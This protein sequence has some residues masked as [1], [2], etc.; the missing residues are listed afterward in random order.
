MNLGPGANI[1]GYRIE[2]VLGAGGMG[3]VYL[4]KHPSLPR[5]DAV[6]VLKADVAE[7]R[8][9]RGRFKREANLSAGLDHPN[10]VTVYDRGDD[11]GRL[12][13]AM[14]Y[15]P[16]I[17]AAEV[18]KSHPRGIG[19]ERALRIVR[20]VG[21]GLDHAHRRG[22]LHRDVK[23]A[24]FLLSPGE[25]E[26]VL[27]TDFGVAKAM[28]DSSELTVTGKF[29]ATVA[30]AAPEQLSDGALSRQTDVY[31]LACSFFK[32][33]TGRNLYPGAQPALVMSGHLYEPVPRITE[34]RPELPR[35][36]DEVLAV[37]L[38]K[39]PDDRFGSCREFTQA[40]ELALE[41][42]LSPVSTPTEPGSVA[43]VTVGPRRKAPAR[44]QMWI[45]SAAAVTVVAAAAGVGLWGIDRDGA[46][47]GPVVTTTVAPVIAKTLA[48]ARQQ[49]PSFLGKKI[50]AVDISGI[51]GYKADLAVYLKP[52]V[53]AAFFEAIGFSYNDSCHKDG[54][55]TSPRHIATSATNGLAEVD[56]PNRLPDLNSGYLLAVRTDSS[57][58]GGGQTNL[59]LTI[60]MRS[61]TVFVL[62]DP[63]AVDALRNWSDKSESIL[64]ERLIPILRK[65]VR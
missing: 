53:Q 57:A 10:I 56:G 54:D 44:K 58:G 16:G 20:E 25:P 47:A 35:A 22:L 37:A 40:L 2:R 21:R 23:P 38:S 18:L 29:V 64:L 59:P 46:A 61:A 4:G 13:I 24:N 63:V 11:D 12:W 30:Y 65:N 8:E 26:R 32:L 45:T 7:D 42:G 48:D 62:D 55:E 27:L 43:A 39:S 60:S 49:N 41:H 31:G 3:T 50:A 6:K 34:L 1:G 28:Q 15:V 52:S 51:G 19:M 33:L 5:W 17:D 36:L 9:F 14:Q